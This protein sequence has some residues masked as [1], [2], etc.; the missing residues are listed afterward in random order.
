MSQTANTKY[1][2]YPFVIKVDR[3][4]TIMMNLENC[5]YCPRTCTRQLAIPV[6]RSSGVEEKN[7]NQ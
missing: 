5:I 4:D 1:V 7:I 6:G 3:Y 2:A